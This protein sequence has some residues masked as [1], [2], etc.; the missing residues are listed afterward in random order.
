MQVGRWDKVTVHSDHLYQLLT[1]IKNADVA[2]DGSVSGLLLYARTGA[3][4]QPA[5]DVVIQGNRIGARTIDLNQPWERLR[6][7][8][9]DVA[10][11]LD[12]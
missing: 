10:T 1:Y 2:R 4:T 9:D 3:P 6:A 11:W 12:P 5:L 8:L 7:R